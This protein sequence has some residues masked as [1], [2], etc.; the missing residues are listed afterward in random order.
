MKLTFFLQILFTVHNLQIFNVEKKKTF[1]GNEF[2]MKILVVKDEQ[3][4]VSCNQSW[5]TLDNDC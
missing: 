1:F 2:S 4:K 3:Y 5:L